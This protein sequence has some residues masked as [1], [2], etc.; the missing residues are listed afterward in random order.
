MEACVKL[1]IKGRVQGV[2]F[3]WFVQR[4]AGRLGVNGYVKNLSSGDV[5]TEAEGERERLEEFVRH[6]EKG[7]PFSRVQE[8][9]TEWKESH[10]KYN[11]FQV[12]F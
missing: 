9:I 6:V 7:P 11:S 3:R 1:T 4:E 8:V 12:E 10:K 2:G 5:E